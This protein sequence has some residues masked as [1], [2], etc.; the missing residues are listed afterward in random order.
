MIMNGA[1]GGGERREEEEGA[2]FA[3]HDAPWGYV[4]LLP[5]G[6]S[7]SPTVNN[8]KLCILIC[9]TTSIVCQ[10]SGSE[11]W[12]DIDHDVFQHQI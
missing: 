9:N 4:A 3:V 10:S 2:H 11:Y 8:L 6:P 7:F 12:Y 5:G 1:P